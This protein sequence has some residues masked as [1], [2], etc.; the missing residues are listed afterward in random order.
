MSD[1]TVFQALVPDESLDEVIE[2]MREIR[3]D[4]PADPTNIRQITVEFDE[5][6]IPMMLDE[7]E[8]ARDE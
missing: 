4:G 3:D 1:Q 8:A 5:T 7:L 6:E 2:D